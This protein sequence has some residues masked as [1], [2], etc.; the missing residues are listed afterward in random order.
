MERFSVSML[1]LYNTNHA[2]RFLPWFEMTRMSVISTTGE[3]FDLTIEANAWGERVSQ[4]SRG[5]SG[6]Q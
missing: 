6:A 3:I 5:L 2:I 4:C 1:I